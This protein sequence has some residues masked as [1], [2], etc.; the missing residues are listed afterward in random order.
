MKPN[1]STFIPLHSLPL[2]V[3][4]YEEWG[5]P[6]NREFFEYMKTY[7]PYENITNK[8]YPNI[9]ITGGLND[10]RVPYWE[11][12]KMTAKLRELKTDNNLLLLKTNMGTGHFGKSGRY[13]Y[14]KDLALI[15]NFILNLSGQSSSDNE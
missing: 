12:A 1:P 15:Y 11:P 6:E 7:S 4:E 13:E 3:I 10:P 9:L 8:N 2:V 5:N 14:L